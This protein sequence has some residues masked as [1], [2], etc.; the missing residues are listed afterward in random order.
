MTDIMEAIYKARMA[1]VEAGLEEPKIIVLQSHDDGMKFLSMMMQKNQW[2][3]DP[4]NAAGRYGTPITD[5]HDETWM[6][7]KVQGLIIRW[8]AVP[9]KTAKGITVWT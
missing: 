5:G 1:F 3:Y 2:V 9:Y 7:V 4:E 8:S 6:D